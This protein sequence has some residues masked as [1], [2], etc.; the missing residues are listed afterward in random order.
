GQGISEEVAGLSA[1]LQ[2]A[3]ARAESVAQGVSKQAEKFQARRKEHDE[4]LEEFR[5]L[6]DRVRNLRAAI[7][8]FRKTEDRAKL[9]TN[10]PALE[11]Q[12]TGLIEDLQKL[13][14]S[15][16]DSRLKGLEKN[17]ESLIQTLQAVHKKLTALL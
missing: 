2:E 16:R 4:K 14:Q 5:I 3:Q 13:R 1:R 9:M 15:A 10:I 11:S 6:G 12:L 8:E 17:T 7:G